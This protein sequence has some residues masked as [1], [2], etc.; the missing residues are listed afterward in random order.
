MLV[1]LP[2]LLV[3]LVVVVVVVL[4]LLLLLVLPNKGLS[5]VFCRLNRLPLLLE[6][7]AGS[8]WGKAFLFL[9]GFVL[10]E[11]LAGLGRRPAQ[12]GHHVP[13]FLMLLNLALH[14]WPSLHSHSILVSQFTYLV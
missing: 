12:V 2:V 5:L 13:W 8:A 7:L 14:R 10:G 9:A 3:L 4:L 6:G 1:V 11:G